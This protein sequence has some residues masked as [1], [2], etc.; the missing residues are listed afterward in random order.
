VN[1]I[2]KHCKLNR[3]VRLFVRVGNVERGGKGLG[4]HHE[5]KEIFIDKESHIFVGYKLGDENGFFYQYAVV[6]K[7]IEAL[8]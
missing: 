1:I 4:K 5:I 7:L 2:I 3:N 6:G 8:N